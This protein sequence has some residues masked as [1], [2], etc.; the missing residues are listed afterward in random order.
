[1]H[2]TMMA[3]G[4]DERPDGEDTPMNEHTTPGGAHHSPAAGARL[5]ARGRSGTLMRDGLPIAWRHTPAAPGVRGPGV[6]FLGG[7]MSD[8]TG[9]KAVALERWAVER[10]VA[11]TRFD[12]RGHGDSGGR[13]DDGT[14]G[15]WAGDA[16]AVLDAVTA[17]P[18][19]L[20]GSSMGGWMM[21]LAALRRPERVAG[22]V[23][24]A[25]APDF[26]EDL[27]WNGIGEEVRGTLVRE[28]RWYRP[29][30][31]FADPKPITLALI[32]D[33]REHLV[34]R[35]SIPFT[36]PVRLLH[37]QEDRDVPW[38]TSLRL[39]AALTSAD[40]WL[41]LVK[42]G[43]HRLSRDA[44]IALLCRTVEELHETLAS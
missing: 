20:V 29:S 32:E 38:N 19:I 5:D 15:A 27:I 14:I 8:M 41:T 42:D 28:G 43:D 33:G 22:L 35:A 18:Q 3:V 44:D 30:A 16:V 17:G 24:I 31:Y 10:G 36:G 34:L 6:M 13:F 21:V 39:S 1:M 11:Y 9:T 26:T 7:F 12:Y 37:G 4:D 2:E 23:G 40:V 25:S